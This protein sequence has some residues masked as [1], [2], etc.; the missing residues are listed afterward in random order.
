[1]CSWQVTLLRRWSTASVKKSMEV[2]ADPWSHSG[3]THCQQVQSA[4][5][6]CEG[7]CVRESTHWCPELSRSP[8]GQYEKMKV[9]YAAQ[10]FSCSTAAAIQTCVNLAILPVEALTTAWFLNFVNDWFDAMNARH[11]ESAQFQCQVTAST[12][13]MTEM[14]H[15][16]KKSGFWWEEDLETN[17]GRH[18]VVNIHSTAAQP[19]SDVNAQ[20]AVLFDWSVVSGSSW[21][22]VFSGSWPRC[23]AP[24]L[25]SFPS[26]TTSCYCCTV[27]PD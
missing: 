3:F 5:W 20:T 23:H 9:H 4:Q 13:A 1:M 15:V 27:P 22:P 24:I 7:I 11:K 8:C 10:F 19:G 25:F 6:H 21:E 26:G 16:I 2:C 12:R 14:L 18:P 17:S